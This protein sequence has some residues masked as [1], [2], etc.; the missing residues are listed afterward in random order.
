MEIYE[1]SCP[2]L[3]QVNIR[4]AIKELAKIAKNSN[5]NSNY[6]T[7]AMIAINLPHNTKCCNFKL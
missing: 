2:R 6:K 5:G 3:F 7:R 4:I 1:G